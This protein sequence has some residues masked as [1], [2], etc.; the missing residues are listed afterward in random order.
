VRNG[1]NQ[2]RHLAVT[3]L[4]EAALLTGD[5]RGARDYLRILDAADARPLAAAIRLRLTALVD[6]DTAPAEEAITVAT[7]HGLMFEEALARLAAARL[8]G[9]DGE[10]RSA[11]AT[12]GRLGAEPWIFEA[13]RAMRARGLA[14]PRST[15]SASGPLNS[16]ELRLAEL[17]QQG[18]TN[19]QIAAA[20]HYSSKTVEV[21]LS[22]V[23]AK[24]GVSTRFALARAMDSGA[25][26]GTGGQGPRPAGSASPPTRGRPGR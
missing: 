4:V 11:L 18:L 9:T 19:R 13:R 17:V 24:V 25:L 6:E 5:R 21:Y 8:G 7:R 3:E 1:W 26:T 16:S 14:L 2:W 22:R 20:M 15:G 23:Y 12:M 10:L